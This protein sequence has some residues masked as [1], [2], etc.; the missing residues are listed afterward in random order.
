MTLRTYVVCLRRK[1]QP[2]I[3]S[4][5]CM[6]QMT[7]FCG[8]LKC[9]IYLDHL[10]SIKAEKARQKAARKEKRDGCATR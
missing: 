1:G 2:R 10:A 7:A 6:A 9:P 3:D 5:I 4:G 8:K